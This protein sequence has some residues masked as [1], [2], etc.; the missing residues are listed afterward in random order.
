MIRYQ[1]YLFRKWNKIHKSQTPEYNKCLFW[2]SVSFSAFHLHFS[3]LLY[4]SVYLFRTLAVNRYV[5]KLNQCFSGWF[6]FISLLRLPNEFVFG[7]SYVT[8]RPLRTID[9]V[10]ILFKHKYRITNNTNNI[11]FFSDFIYIIIIMNIMKS[12][13]N[14][15]IQRKNCSLKTSAQTQPFLKFNPHFHVG[16]MQPKKRKTA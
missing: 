12:E 8:D 11:I 7:M 15:L 1:T 13:V 3:F 16:G 9:H 14:F 6:S 2:I 10:Q 4:S 5:Q